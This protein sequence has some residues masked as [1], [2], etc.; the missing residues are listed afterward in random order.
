MTALADQLP[1]LAAV[2]PID[3]GGSK[4]NGVLRALTSYADRGREAVTVRELA[5]RAKVDHGRVWHLVTRLQ[6]DGYLTVVWSKSGRSLL[7]FAVLP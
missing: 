6:A 5:E 7:S 4:R 1:T 3:A 2:L